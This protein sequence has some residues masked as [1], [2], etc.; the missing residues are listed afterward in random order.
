M[1]IRF[2]LDES[3]QLKIVKPLRAR[4]I[5][6]S[7]PKDAGLLSAPDEAHL[8]YGQADGRVV[9]AHD[10]DYLVL[11][12]NSFAHAGIAYSHQ[13]KYGTG[14]LLH[15]LVL[16]HSCYTAEEMVNRREFL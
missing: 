2:H 4:G 11:H 8:F 13:G 10:D 5:D 1:K 6:V 7:T 14:E 9:V 15:V 3:V 12:E 16:L